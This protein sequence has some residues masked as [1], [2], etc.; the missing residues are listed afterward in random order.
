MEPWRDQKN[1][2]EAKSSL[3]VPTKVTVKQIDVEDGYGTTT[4]SKKDQIEAE[5]SFD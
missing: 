2:N 1:H 5:V 3:G 4:R